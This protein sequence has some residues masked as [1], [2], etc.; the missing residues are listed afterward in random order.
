MMLKINSKI[1]IVIHSINIYLYWAVAHVGYSVTAEVYECHVVH[2]L[3]IVT[4]LP[5][6]IAIYLSPERGL[7]SLHCCGDFP[8]CMCIYQKDWETSTECCS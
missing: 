5:V 3:V 2:K 1:T 6:A 4:P 8:R 7:T